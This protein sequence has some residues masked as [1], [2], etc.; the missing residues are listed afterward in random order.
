MDFIFMFTREDLTVEDCL[1]VFD[2]IIQTGVKHLGFKD[3]GVP[4]ET[5]VELNNRIK[6]S[7]GISYMEVV[8]TTGEACLKSARAAVEIGV[9]RLLGGTQ[10]E[11]MLEVLQGSGIAYFP[12]PGR[13]IGHPTKLGGTPVQVAA[14]CRRFEALGCAGVDLLAYRA[15][16]AEPLELVRTARQALR[17]ELIVAGSV[18]NPARV[19][20]LAE[21]GV[22][23][24]TVGSAAFDGSFS[25]RK[26]SLRSQISDIL[27][28][29][30]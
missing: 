1:D 18:G 22:D 5:L 9:D 3:I 27:A 14:D 16:E 23:A 20:E 24:F 30:T 29:C 15:T 12:F 10:A 25:P 28:A 6:A 2:I 21:A 19:H 17:G 7:G 8:S 4:R 11:A 26:G 13:P